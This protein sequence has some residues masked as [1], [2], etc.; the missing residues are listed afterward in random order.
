MDKTVIFIDIY[1][2]SIWHTAALAAVSLLVCDVVIF[3]VD[4]L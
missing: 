3:A 1:L 4:G 2:F